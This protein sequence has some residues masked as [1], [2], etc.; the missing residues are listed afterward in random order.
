MIYEFE[1]KQYEII[2]KLKYKHLKH[3]MS[4]GIEKLRNM[5][6]TPDPELMEYMLKNFVIKPKLTDEVLDE[7]EIDEI[8]FLMIK[9]QNVEVPN[10]S[11]LK[12][13]LS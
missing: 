5:K 9:V 3:L 8:I 10:I 12:K 6:N 1:G 7:M 11:E 2:N 13:K 4:F